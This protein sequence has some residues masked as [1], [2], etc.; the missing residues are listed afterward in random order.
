MKQFQ[1]FIIFKGSLHSMI[2]DSQPHMKHKFVWFDINFG[3]LVHVSPLRK[4]CT[5]LDKAFRCSDSIYIHVIIHVYIPNWRSSYRIV[6]T[7]LLYS[8]ILGGSLKGLFKMCDFLT[9]LFNNN[10]L[11]TDCCF[12]FN[13]VMGGSSL[14][15]K[16]MSYLSHYD[17][18]AYSHSIQDIQQMS[19][20][21]RLKKLHQDSR[22]LS[23]FI[24][25]T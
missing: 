9:L 19:H 25:F 15:F 23:I 21:P 18:F 13:V 22:R 24:S 17:P 8:M 20:D 12:K 3:S 11:L 7:R 4:P 14:I 6:I 5:S 1:D 10:I 2:G 16:S